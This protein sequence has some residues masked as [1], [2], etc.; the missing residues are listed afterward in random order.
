[1]LTQEEFM[2]VQALKR[3]GLTITEIAAEL[4]YHPATISRWLQAGGPPRHRRTQ[5]PP[6]IDERWAGRIAEL[7]RRS[8]R[9]LATSVFEILVA[10]GFEGS[11]ATVSRHVHS[12]RGPRFRT[13]PRVSVRIETAPGE[14][15]QFDF[16]DVS[17]FTERWGLGEVQCF[18][19][20]LCW[21]RWRIWWFTTSVDKEHTFE[22]LVRF[23]EAAGGVPRICRTDRMGALGASQGRRFKLH[24]P[25]LAFAQAHGIEIRACQPADAARK[26]KVERPF[27]DTKERFLAELDALGTPTS[28]AELNEIA[29]RWVEERVHGR[30]HRTT[31]VPPAER[32]VA[33]RSLLG[34]L[35]RRRYDT[36]YVEARRVHVAVPMLEW[37]G[38]SYSV[39]PSALGQRVEVRQE[40]DEER[41]E[42]RFAGETIAIHRLATGEV[43]EVW[44]GAHFQAAQRAALGRHRRHLHVVRE[45]ERPVVTR[46]F[47]LP[48]G[49]Y[50]V[51]PLDLGRYEPDV[52]DIG[53]E[54]S[55]DI[56]SGANTEDELPGGE[57]L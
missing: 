30:V 16:S 22:G 32:L 1:M 10:E 3:Q 57:A 49:D 44:D 24:P 47:E 31:G 54:G 28:I 25:A 14:E 34:P 4:G 26:G 40:M 18:Q 36:A 29:R 12:M 5:A 38:V 9:L 23:F 43:R 55:V 2:D 35:P 17:S 13:E 51:A 21:S 7:L 20:I 52:G 39:P 11:Y 19:A 33:E 6:L 45:E 37:R 56:A 53:V 27:R 41:I 42:V 50:D 8:P 46:R 48:D 15:C